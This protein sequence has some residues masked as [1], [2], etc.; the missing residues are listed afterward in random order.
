MFFRRI[1]RDYRCKC[2]EDRKPE[3]FDTGSKVGGER[4]LE[5]I[6][7]S[8]SYAMLGAA[9][10]LGAP[11]LLDKEDRNTQIVAWR[12]VFVGDPTEGRLPPEQHG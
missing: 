9:M 3:L 1:Q 11:S 2:L 7:L 5:P 4:Y 12:A 6:W 10:G 8:A